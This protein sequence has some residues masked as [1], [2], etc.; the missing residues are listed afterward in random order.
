MYE[1]G[2]GDEMYVYEYVYVYVWQ[3]CRG[4]EKKSRLLKERALCRGRRRRL[5]KKVRGKN[6][7]RR[8]VESFNPTRDLTNINNSLRV[9]V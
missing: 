6:R 5:L 1:Y 8:K 2:N 3:N 4:G 7:E 9:G